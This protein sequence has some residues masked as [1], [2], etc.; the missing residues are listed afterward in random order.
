M[1]K[2]GRDYKL[3]LED[4]LHECRNIYFELDNKILWDTVESDLD[5]FESVVREMMKSL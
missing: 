1:F 4:I 3:Y 2:S 5:M